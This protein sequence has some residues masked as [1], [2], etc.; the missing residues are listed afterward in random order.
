MLKENNALQQTNHFFKEP[1]SIDFQSTSSCSKLITS[2]SNV[3][4]NTTSIND[5]N[6][7]D[8]PAN[9]P[10]SINQN[11]RT[12]IVILG[13][14]RIFN[15]NFPSRLTTSYS[16]ERENYSRFSTKFYY[17]KLFN[18][19]K[20]DRTWLVYSISTDRVYCFC[21]KLFVND[22]H[23][24]L[25]TIGTNDW[26][27]LG[28]KLIE[29]ERSLAHLRCTKTWF[30]LKI[31][32][33]NMSSIDKTNLEII[34]KEKIHWKNVL[35]RILAAIQYLAK[36]NDAFRSTSDIIFTKNNGKFLGLIEMIGKFNPVI[37]E[38]LRRKKITIPMCI[39]LAMIYRNV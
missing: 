23:G 4:I 14:K 20:V 10:I 8:D 18:G 30:D 5:F 16:T 24:S 35:K 37:E 38:H 6:I 19:E 34:E 22:V 13:P 12:D 29:H 3:T 11:L 2:E 21:C 31:R 27:Y 7:Y 39:I 33:Q 17:R 15:F 32:I 28:S 1:S 36:H 26:N 25:S 9:W